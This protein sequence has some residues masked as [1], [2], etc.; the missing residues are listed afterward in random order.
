[1]V[2]TIIGKRLAQKIMGVLDR[3]ELSTETQ[4]EMLKKLIDTSVESMSDMVFGGVCLDDIFTYPTLGK[5][6]KERM[7][8][9]SEYDKLGYQGF[10]FKHQAIFPYNPYGRQHKKRIEEEIRILDETLEKLY[11]N[12]S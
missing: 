5:A 7:T 6:I 11:W 4:D 3:S 9:K 2:K 10:I 8:F 1:M 12:K